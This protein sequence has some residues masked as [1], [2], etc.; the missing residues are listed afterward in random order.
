MAKPEV[1]SGEKKNRLVEFYKRFNKISFAV[2]ATAGVV[3]KS[4]VLLGLA[5]IDLTQIYLVNR[6]QEWNKRRKAG[7]AAGRAALQPA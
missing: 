3:L 1:Q 7:K 4:E 5:A 6:I 2:L